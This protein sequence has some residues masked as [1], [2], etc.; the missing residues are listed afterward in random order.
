MY[1]VP[2]CVGTPSIDRPF[3]VEIEVSN[4]GKA[5]GYE[6]V[7]WY[8][9]DPYCSVLTRPEKELKYFEK[10]FLKAGEKAT[11]VFE[12]DPSRDLGYL[13]GDG[14]SFLESG[15]YHVIVGGRDLKIMI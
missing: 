5:D 10:K 7:L 3:K 9:S 15:E 14:R 11:F 12:V 2:R 1:V 8:I 6:T 13:D 4:T